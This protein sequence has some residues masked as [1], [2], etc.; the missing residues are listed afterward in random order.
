MKQ[1]AFRFEAELEVN[2]HAGEIAMC[3][4]EGGKLR[5]RAAKIPAALIFCN[6]ERD[7]LP[8]GINSNIGIVW[9]SASGLEEL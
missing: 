7:S 3:V 2:E 6:Q 4:K 1:V 9:R 5:F 8:R